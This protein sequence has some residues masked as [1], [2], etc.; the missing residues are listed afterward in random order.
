GNLGNSSIRAI[1]PLVTLADIPAI[2]LAGI[3]AV[4]TVGVLVAVSAVVL[5][6][7]A[8]DVPVAVSAV[9]L[10][11]AAVV[12]VVA[13]V[14]LVVVAAIVVLV[15]VIAAFGLGREELFSLSVLFLLLYNMTLSSSPTSAPFL[16]L[17]FFTPA[18]SL[19]CLRL[20]FLFFFSSFGFSSL[21]E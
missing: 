11:V 12:L 10:V 15:A 18:P 4:V 19:L 21:V 8:A 1:V 20:T 6:V 17:P 2:V 16:L 7:V 14:V 9:I 13:A 3:L 5:A